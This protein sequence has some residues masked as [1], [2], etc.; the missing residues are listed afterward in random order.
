[1]GE[2][3]PVREY[4]TAQGRFRGLL[5]KDVG[6]IQENVDRDWGELEKVAVQRKGKCR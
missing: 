2:K 5:E 4:L 3:V 1:M 6:I